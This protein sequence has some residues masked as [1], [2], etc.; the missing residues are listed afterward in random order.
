MFLYFFRALFTEKVV[1]VVEC[2]TQR[3]V[4]EKVVGRVVENSKSLMYTGFKDIQYQFGRVVF[5]T[6][7]ATRLMFSQ[8][9]SG[10]S[11]RWTGW[12]GNI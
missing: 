9:T 12:T 4:T 11:I 8:C 2:D 7:P 6:R 10:F 3:G 5:P 1:G